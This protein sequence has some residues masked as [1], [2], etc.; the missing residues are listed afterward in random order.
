MANKK[1]TAVAPAV[2]V[3]DDLLAVYEA[4]ELKQKERH[5]E[6]GKNVPYEDVIGLL[7]LILPKIRAAGKDINVSALKDVITEQLEKRYNELPEGMDRVTVRVGREL[8]EMT[9]TEFK[10]L[11]LRQLQSSKKTNMVYR[12]IYGYTRK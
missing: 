4:A 7:K 2:E 6:V 10:A 3:T 11:R 1:A 12:Y 5:V 8:V 9:K